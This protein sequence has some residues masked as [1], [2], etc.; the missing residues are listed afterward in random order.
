MPSGPENAVPILLR[1]CS[2]AAS[3]VSLLVGLLV[4][5]GGWAFGIEAIKAGYL[6]S[7]R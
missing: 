6:G 5:V 3:I 1:A 2:A 4:L 7:P